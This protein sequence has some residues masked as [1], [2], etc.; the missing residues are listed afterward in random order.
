MKG[1][2]DTS[3]AAEI[4]SALTLNTT[5][6]A[7]PSNLPSHLT[8][9]LLPAALAHHTHRF[10]SP[11]Y[12]GLISSITGING[13][14][15]PGSAPMGHTTSS[16]SSGFPQRDGG[17][18]NLSSVPTLHSQNPTAAVSPSS[19]PDDPLDNLT[20]RP[21]SLLPTPPSAPLTRHAYLSMIENVLGK[22][23]QTILSDAEQPV[24]ANARELVK[25]WGGG[26]GGSEVDWV[27]LVTPFAC[28][29]SRN[30]AVYNGFRKLMDRMRMFR[31]TR[32]KQVC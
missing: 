8:S 10:E 30:V 26:W 28:C 2:S 31:R 4:T 6:T 7:L 18:S 22:Y 16:G 24:P 23:Y 29:L 20:L 15:T 9:L 3:A 21:R 11:T 14:P 1:G 32:T 27:Y 12:A 5:Y 17:S 13:T 25:A 19:S